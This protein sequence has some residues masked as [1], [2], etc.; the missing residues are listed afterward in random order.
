MS[1]KKINLKITTPDKNFFQGEVD[2]VILRAK[3]GEIGI[4]PN[5]APLVTVLDIGS[6]R[7]KQGEDE[8]KAV[9]NEGFLK[10]SKNQVDI[11]TDSA[12]WPD[13]IDKERARRAKE[14]A[15]RRLAQKESS[16]DYE[17]VN[18]AL[19][20]AINRIKFFE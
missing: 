15:E 10:V 6:I 13:E 3:S 9:L 2:M 11:F 20:R 4:L 14:R 18:L 8:K 19:K 17:R 12:E 1:L 16:M 5:H 7:I